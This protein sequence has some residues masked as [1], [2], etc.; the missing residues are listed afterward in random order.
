MELLDRIL[1]ISEIA[2]TINPGQTDKQALVRKHGHAV[3]LSRI[4][5][6]IICSK[7]GPGIHLGPNQTIVRSRNTYCPPTA[8][9]SLPC[10]SIPLAIRVFKETD[11]IPRREKWFRFSILVF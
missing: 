7:D 11:N 2:C 3:D 8:I 5:I 10:R 6:M 4:G 9:A 1:A